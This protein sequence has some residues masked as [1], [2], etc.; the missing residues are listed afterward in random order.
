M[1]LRT[2]H[3]RTLSNGVCLTE[4]E[5]ATDVY[6]GPSAPLCG[7]VGRSA[8]MSPQ[9]GTGLGAVRHFRRC[10]D[11]VEVQL[12]SNHPT[13][14]HRHSKLARWPMKLR[15]RHEVSF[16]A[17]DA[18]LHG[19]IGLPS[20]RLVRGRGLRGSLPDG[21]EPMF[22]LYLLGRRPP[23]VTWEARWIQWHDFWLPSNPAAAALALREAWER[24][25][26]ER[27]EIACSGG[28][29]RTGTALA[30]LAILDGVPAKEAVA[31]VR[32]HY[33]PRV[34]ETPWQRRFVR[35]FP[36]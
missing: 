29:G 31:Y 1:P 12:V 30:C 28:N 10:L 35:R 20:G 19:V 24:A 32:K 4:N 27:V 7:V 16:T 22:G 36:T 14:L 2:Q 15:Y 34:V 33:N 18:N 26:S 21:L 13:C 3:R 17:W 5:F 25:E 23:V 11:A 9:I 6:F 8:S